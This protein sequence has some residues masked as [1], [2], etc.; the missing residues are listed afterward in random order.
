MSAY[1]KINGQECSGDNR[2]VRDILKKEW[3]FDGCV[4]CDWGAV[5]DSVEASKGGIDL[6]MPLSPASS[7]YLEEAVQDGRLD[8]ALLD[9][10]VRNI[11]KLVQRLSESAP[12]DSDTE[13]V[14]K[15]QIL[16]KALPSGK[17][18]PI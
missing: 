17:T 2:Y 10:R 18:E 16:Q 5:K 4:I 7:K 6:Q 15:R 9:E 3:G 12:A 13:D 14:Y 8:E 11:L 1:N